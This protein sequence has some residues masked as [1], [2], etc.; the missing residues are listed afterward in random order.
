MKVNESYDKGKQEIPIPE[1]L[2]EFFNLS[3]SDTLLD[4]LQTLEKK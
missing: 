4:Q 2:C 1:F 3:H